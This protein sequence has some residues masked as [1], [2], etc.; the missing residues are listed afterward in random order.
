MIKENTE[1]C[2]DTVCL[3]RIID[4]GVNLLFF[5]SNDIIEINKLLNLRNLEK[6]KVKILKQMHFKEHDEI[7]Y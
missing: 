6:Y 1:L 7:E 5:S 3:S 4:E 2:C